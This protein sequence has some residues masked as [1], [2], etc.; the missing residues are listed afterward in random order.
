MKTIRCVVSG[1][2][3]GVYYRANVK[4]QADSLGLTGWVRNL[5]NGSVELIAQGQ[6]E[7]VEKLHKWI[8]AG[9]VMAKVDDVKIDIIETQNFEDF[10]VRRDE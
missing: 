5:S 8:W 2:V 7:N 1:R 6:D 9:P 10:T 3:Q 4:K